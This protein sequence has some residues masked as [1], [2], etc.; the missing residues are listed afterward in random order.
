[1]AL[2]L[3]K[4]KPHFCQM[5]SKK[6]AYHLLL[7]FFIIALNFLLPR[8]MPGGPTAYLEG[9][10]DDSPMRIISQEQKEQL[11]AYYHLDQP[12]YSQFVHFIKEIGKLDLGAS[13]HYQSSVSGVIYAH[14]QWTFLLVGISIFLSVFIGIFMGVFSAWI[15]GSRRDSVY[16]YILPCYRCYPNICAC[17]DFAAFFQY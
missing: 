6:I 7:F 11:L 4:I 17:Y 8:L 5:T 13:I 2:P 1:M 16:L 10:G 9:G 12:L 15:Q 3:G 14:A